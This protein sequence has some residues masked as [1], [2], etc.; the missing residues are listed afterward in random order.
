MKEIV[1][2]LK[3]LREEVLIFPN[4]DLLIHID[5][6]KTCKLETN[7]NID[8]QTLRKILRSANSVEKKTGINPICMSEGL[9]RLTSNSKTNLAPIFLIPVEIEINKACDDYKLIELEEEKI[10]NPYLINHF[11]INTSEEF[12]IK[13]I[14]D[15]QSV[16]KVNPNDC[17]KGISF[18]GNF[19]PKRFSF[20][21]EIEDLIDDKISYSNAL[22][23][24][25]GI[26]TIESSIQLQTNTSLFRNDDDQLQVYD[27]LSDASIVVQGPPGTGKSQVIG[28][29]LGNALNSNQSVLLC[30]EKKVA[31]DV[32]QNK[33]SSRGLSFLSFQIPSRYP[34]RSLIY[35]LKKGWDIFNQ[36]K[37]RPSISCFK[38]L[39]KKSKL[40]TLFTKEAERQKC[41]TIEIIELIERNRKNELIFHNQTS[42]EITA[43]NSSF[44]VL[45]Q[46]PGHVLS[47][48]KTINPIVLN[49]SFL[50]FS[51]ELVPVIEVLN[52]LNS[53]KKTV[54]WKDIHTVLYE[55]LQ[56]HSFKQ[57]SYTKFGRFILEQKDQFK[58][59]EME[60]IKN[61]LMIET[62][63]SEQQHWIKEPSLEE[64]DFLHKLFKKKHLLKYKIK[65]FFTWRKWSRSPAANPE[66]QI[67]NRVRYNKR[68]I[69]QKTIEKK[70]FDLGIK[71]P[72]IELSL[73][74]ALIKNTDINH[75][76]KYQEETITKKK[77]ISHKNLYRAINFLKHSFDF[78]PNDKPL[79][80]LNN[81]IANKDDLL[82]S[83]PKLNHLPK[84]IFPYLNESLNEIKNSVENAIFSQIL[85][86]NPE[87]KKFSL[88]TFINDCNSINSDFDKEA[89]SFAQQLITRQHEL[90]I[91][92][93]DLTKTTPRKLSEEQKTFRKKL[94]KGKSILVKEFGKKRAHRSIRDLFNSEALLWIRILKPIWMSNPNTLADSLP[95]TN[96]LF[97]YLIA[98]EAS[99][100]LLSHSVGALQRA[101][102]TII[103]GDPQQ[104]APSSFFKKKQKL[105]INLLHHANYY[106]KH[107]FLSNHYR[108]AHPQLIKFSNSHFYNNRLKAFQD[109]NIIDKP[110]QHYHVKSAVFTDRKNILEAQ[111]VAAF[112]TKKIKAKEKLGIVAFSET[113]LECIY[114]NLNEETIVLLEKRIDE[115]TLFFQSLEKVQ[116]DECDRLIVSFGY[117]FNSEKKFEMRFGPV[118]LNQGHKRLNVLFSRAKRNIDFFS[119]VTYSDFPKTENE[120]VIHLKKW[121]EILHNREDLRQVD[122][123]IS[124][125]N[126][127][128]DCDG[129]NDLITYLHVYQ[130]RGYKINTTLF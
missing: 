55:L 10:L 110:I 34:N 129:F 44:D 45:Q 72:N 25:C 8:F 28:N 94:K 76:K 81:L 93:E 21:R 102:K 115:D 15:F 88:N 86:R 119:S 33:L 78:G 43:F 83:W 66:S 85:I 31:L 32:I 50:K 39:Q 84:Q 71:D 104:M 49:E 63:G 46:I 101:K 90:F 67:K 60:Y 70:M 54:A 29:L 13:K 42:L 74:N 61:K 5:S 125:K 123:N 122:K 99:Q 107:I 69:R 127:L 114:E 18:I 121:F 51:N 6:K 22:K 87:F 105:E 35:E 79:Y 9:V 106:L 130:N 118:N 19:H 11:S 116:G 38:E 126:I 23:E 128:E 65:W 24:I 30:S 64:L 103:C 12:S 113:Q 109:T 96:S 48:A 77:N 112:I 100:L 111:K 20:L 47:M 92:Y 56:F 57:D 59:L 62:L 14:E 41:S 2:F 120:G 73:I 97:D 82:E 58:R 108:S 98:D 89:D 91:A 36:L 3:E 27:K 68:K 95:L 75:W 17:E 40:F 4:N 26:E 124:I 52:E 1:S 16:C 117:G 37:S 7:E 80:I 53:N